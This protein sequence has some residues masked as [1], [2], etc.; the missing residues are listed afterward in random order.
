[1]MTFCLYSLFVKCINKKLSP[2]SYFYKSCL[3]FGGI[4]IY[5]NFNVGERGVCEYVFLWNE[6]I[7]S[8]R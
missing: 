2:F 1:M 3:S 7:F 8:Q 4:L 5:G 6:R